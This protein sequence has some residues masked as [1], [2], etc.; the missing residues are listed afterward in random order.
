MYWGKVNDKW[1]TDKVHRVP[2]S[3]GLA[4]PKCGATGAVDRGDAYA[5]YEAA[6]AAFLKEPEFAAF[7][8]FAYTVTQDAQGADV[9]QPLDKPRTVFYREACG[10]PTLGASGLQDNVKMVEKPDGFEGHWPEHW[11]RA[12]RQMWPNTSAWRVRVPSNAAVMWTAHGLVLAGIAITLGT[13]V[14]GSPPRAAPEPSDASAYDF[15]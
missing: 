6:E 15:D 11:S 5:T 7:D 13:V 8:F 2:Y 3:R 4:D 1:Y 14:F 9:P 12:E 10:T